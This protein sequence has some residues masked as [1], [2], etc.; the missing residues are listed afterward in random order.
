MEEQYLP[1]LFGCL[2][3]LVLIVVLF[4]T[5]AKRVMC[6]C[7]NDILKCD[8]GPNCAHC[9]CYNN[10]EYA[11]AG[12]RSKS[13]L[14]VVDLHRAKRGHV[15]RFDNPPE[16]EKCRWRTHVDGNGFYS[17]FKHDGSPIIDTP[18]FDHSAYSAESAASAINSEQFDRDEILMQKRHPVAGV[19]IPQVGRGS[20]QTIDTES[21]A[22][23]KEPPVADA[24]SKE[25]ISVADVATS[26]YVSA[27][28]I[29]NGPKYKNVGDY[30]VDVESQLDQMYGDSTYGNLDN[31]STVM[32][33]GVEVEGMRGG[34]PRH[35]WVNRDRPFR[36]HGWRRGYNIAPVMTIIDA[37]YTLPDTEDPDSLG[38]YANGRGV[39]FNKPY[40][41]SSSD[42]VVHGFK[43]GDVWRNTNNDK[44]FVLV[45][46]TA[47]F[48]QWVGVSEVA[49]MHD[50]TTRPVLR[51]VQ[52]KK[53]RGGIRSY[54][55]AVTHVAQGPLDS[56]AIK[57]P[58][59]HRVL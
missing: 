48:A 50:R 45:D 11:T 12:S 56:V 7:G 5:K 20:V 31:A 2:I 28:G 6:P 39:K 18:P 37:T 53:P 59:S 8:C 21:D 3:V 17:N 54:T 49:S 58:A 32:D 26:D 29:E 44:K 43:K 13:K 38:V 46:Q 55:K 51:G 30:G 10:M 1:V 14:R 25:P 23:N 15:E 40:N 35:R 36:G 52:S 33:P 34:G 27:S 19:V 57:N 42:D 9:S 22:M 41:P 24:P 16:T 47:G 4:W